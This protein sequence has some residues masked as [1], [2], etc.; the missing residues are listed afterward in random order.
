MHV[1]TPL[2]W[3]NLATIGPTSK[4]DIGGSYR[5]KAYNFE[6]V[7]LRD[8]PLRHVITRRNNK[9]HSKVV[10]GQVWPACVNDEGK[11]EWWMNGRFH[12]ERIN[13]IEQPS[14]IWPNGTQ[15]WKS[16]LKFSTHRGDIDGIRQPGFVDVGSR[17][18]EWWYDGTRTRDA[19]DGVSKDDWMVDEQEL[20]R[21]YLYHKW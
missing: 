6:T 18:L 15:V 9:C 10:D 1:N 19:V 14:I 13:D 2:T 11:Q 4:S 3:L 7:E 16:G 8:Y 17:Q 5:L 12:R 21:Q 20:L